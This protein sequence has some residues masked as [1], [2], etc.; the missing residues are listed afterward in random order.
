MMAFM[1]VRSSWLMLARKADLVSLART[2]DMRA[3]SNLPR[4]AMRLSA[5][6]LKAW[7]SSPSSSREWMRMRCLRSPPPM[8]RAPTFSEFSPRPM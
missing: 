7:A 8:M 6:E 1:G 5:M 3:S 4:A 2:A